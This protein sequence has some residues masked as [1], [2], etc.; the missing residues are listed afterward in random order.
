MS[1][2]ISADFPVS[3]KIYLN[4]AS[5]SLMPSQSISAMNDFLISYNS[6]GP[7]SSDSACL[8]EEKLNNVRK[9]IAKI[10]CCKSEEVILTQSTTDGINI[11]ANGLSFDDSSNII[12]RGMTHEHHSNFYPW[13]K[14]KNKISVRNLPIDSNGFFKL[15]DL[16]SNVD[17]N[18]KLLAISHALY[19]TGSILPVE[20]ISASLKKEIPFFIDS[21]QT[22]GCIGTHDVSKL[23]C[24]FM[25]F[26][27][28]KWLCGPMGTGL[29][30]CKK[31]SSELLEPKTVGGESAIIENDNN[32]IFKDIPEKFQTGFRNY[33]GI[34]GLES[35]VKY[36]LNFG[37]ENIRKKNQ[38]LS[39]IF[40]DELMKIPDVVLYGPEDP[41]KRTS[42][43]S[44]NIKNF[45]SE[46]VVKKLEKQNIILAVREIMEKK[47]I[48]VSPHFFNNESDMLKV[49]DEIK[50]L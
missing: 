49:I 5:V 8:I 33:V 34:V 26:N 9:I 28:S 35:S 40:R 15:D 32:L 12:I 39:N 38:N 31:E 24:D 44:F 30:Y 16:K 37:M 13:I 3:N 21:A 20:K 4:N 45:D 50:K 17:N 1:K 25:S 29:F 19:N 48:R 2:D 47:I 36:L 22:I 43:V 42:I 23:G 6:L 46:K 14:L 11:V 18:T 7:D 27:G 41:D 10:I